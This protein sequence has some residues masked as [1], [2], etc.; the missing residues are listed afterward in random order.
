[1]E[2]QQFGCYNAWVMEALLYPQTYLRENLAERAFRALERLVLLRP[3]EYLPEGVARRLAQE[4]RVRFLYPPPLGEKLETFLD[5][6]AGYEE[7]GLMMRTPENVALFKAFPEPLEESVSDIKKAL[8]GEK[9]RED[10]LLSARILLALA[11]RLDQKLESLD[12]ELKGL[13]EKSQFLSRMIVG[14]ELAEMRFPSWVIE[15]REPFWK[16]QALPQR[17][18]AWARLVSVLPEIPE[19]FLVNQ[20]EILEEWQDFGAQ[21]VELMEFEELSVKVHHLE[22][23]VPPQALL[24]YPESGLIQIPGKTR[25]LFLEYT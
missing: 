1:L 20:S 12:Q 18:V 16:L 15:I 8:L 22:Y 14:E 17:M 10:P 5:L 19:V 24:S 23:P 6:V 13:E 25:V 9:N 4:N 2:I 3:A 21:E 7:W 11:E